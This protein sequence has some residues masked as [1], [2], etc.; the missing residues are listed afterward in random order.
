VRLASLLLLGACNQVLGIGE[1]HLP[2]DANACL[3]HPGDPGFHDEDGD[4]LADQC[5]N[6]PTTSNPPVNGAQP[7]GDGDGVG[8]A[9]D[10]HPQLRGDKIVE[11]EYFYGDAFGTW[12]PNSQGWTTDA[13]SISSPAGTTGTTSLDHGQFVARFPTM[14][15]HFTVLAVSSTYKLELALDYPGFGSDCYIDEEVD[16]PYIWADNSGGG[17][18]VGFGDVTAGHSYVARMSRDLTQITC[19]IADGTATATNDDLNDTSVT[20]RIDVEHMQVQ[21]DSIT[22]YAYEKP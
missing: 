21:I 14:D 2:V 10:P 12:T 17:G 11:V 3:L 8:D 5:D 6:C 15:V 13:D 16:G 22:L 19:A 4:G 9:C 18:G 7:D 1:T 20:P